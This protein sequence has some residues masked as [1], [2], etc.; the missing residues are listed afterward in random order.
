MS[1]S[2]AAE[3]A[4]KTASKRLKGEAGVIAIDRRGQLAAVHNTPFLPW[5]FW[6]TGMG[7]PRTA[8][9][10]KIVAPLR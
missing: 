10:G 6:A 4:V 3:L 9:R 7:P 5:S 8:L 1:A 2:R